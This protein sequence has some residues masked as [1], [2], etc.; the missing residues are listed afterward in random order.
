VSG[1]RPG[2]LHN[3][4]RLSDSRL[5]AD[6]PDLLLSS[7]GALPARPKKVNFLVASGETDTFLGTGGE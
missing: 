7:N 6:D 4:S 5:A 1:Y 3:K 2:K